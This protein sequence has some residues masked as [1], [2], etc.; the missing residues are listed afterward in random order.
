MPCYGLAESTLMVSGHPG[1]IVRHYDK[2]A[3]LKN[4]VYKR[5]PNDEKVSAIVACEQAVQDLLIVNPETKI[6]CTDKQIGEI[7]LSSA[8]IAKG[9]WNQ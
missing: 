6:P 4:Q 8:N 9:Y 2:E 7:W 1:V 3:L 5:E